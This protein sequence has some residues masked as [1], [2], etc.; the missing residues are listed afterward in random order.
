MCLLR[1]FVVPRVTQR[2]VVSR[3]CVEYQQ[4]IN[5]RYYS[6]IRLLASGTTVDLVK[7]IVMKIYR[8]EYI[9]TKLGNCSKHHG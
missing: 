5:N 4:L 8:F 7:E 1:N 3:V 9:D 2:A 6:V